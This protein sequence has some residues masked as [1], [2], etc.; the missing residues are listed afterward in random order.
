M[1]ALTRIRNE[2]LIIEDTLRHLLSYA[3][4]VLVYDDASTDNTVEICRSFENVSVIEGG[5]WRL[6][7]QHEETR[8]RHVLLEAAR[9]RGAEWALYMDA[10]ERLVGDLPSMDKASPDGYR[11]QLF[12]GYMTPDHSAEYLSGTL[13]ELPRLYGPERRDILML[14]RVS[15][16]RYMGLDQREPVVIGRQSTTQVFVKHFGKCLSVDHWEDTCDYYVTHFPEPYRSKWAARKGKAI[17]TLSD[18]ERPLY[19][20]NELI[21]DPSLHVRI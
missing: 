18:F 21:A 19:E 1:I 11:F 10:D 3:P 6:N 7:R 20:W 5:Q 4:Q 15:A 13:A 12:D 14:F 8:H 2:S 16:A 9:A 17:H